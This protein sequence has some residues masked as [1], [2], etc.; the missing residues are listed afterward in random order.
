MGFHPSR[1]AYSVPTSVSNNISNKKGWMVGTNAS[2]AIGIPANLN[3]YISK[4]TTPFNYINDELK[5]DRNLVV[6]QNTLSGVGKYRSQFISSADGIKSV[7]YYLE[8]P[9]DYNYLIKKQ[10][11]LESIA[12]N[13]DVNKYEVIILFYSNATSN[14]V[15]TATNGMNVTAFFNINMYSKYQYIF[16][17]FSF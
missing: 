16:I 9:I 8:E 10:I 7:R 4:R 17:K 3:K 11:Y 6:V 12:E 13:L 15:S 1:R 14:D 2:Y 5:D